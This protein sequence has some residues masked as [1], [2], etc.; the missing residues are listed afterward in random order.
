M[1]QW[2]RV[3]IAS[4]LG[5]GLWAG[6]AAQAA[7]IENFQEYYKQSCDFLTGQSDYDDWCNGGNAPDKSPTVVMIGDSYS[8]SASTMLDEYVLTDKSGL[9]FQQYGH[10]QCPELLGYGPAW[11][12]GF[13]QKVY[14]H[15]KKTKSIKTVIMTAAWSQHYLLTGLFKDQTP[16]TRAAFTKAFVETIKAYQALGVKVVVMYQTPYIQDPK[17]CVQRRIQVAQT[18]AKC[19]LPLA[20]AYG[21]EEYR[22]FFDPTLA[23]LK[24]EVFDPYVYLCNQA[25]CLLKEGDKIF[26]TAG[27]HLSGFGGQYL[28]RKGR[29][30]LAAL[31]APPATPPRR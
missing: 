7:Q 11:C 23:E 14:E 29:A 18:Q 21:K 26:H 4:L 17:V 6:M 22:Q 12:S 28:A 24:V 2:M 30:R 16:R 15:I 13:A 10:S 31:L 5:C 1:K 20:Q 19:E 8:N 3:F 27:E 25:E 9:V